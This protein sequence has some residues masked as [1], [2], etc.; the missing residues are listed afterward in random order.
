MILNV[1]IP[2]YLSHFSC[3]FCFKNVTTSVSLEIRLVFTL[4]LVIYINLFCIDSG[5]DKILLQVWNKIGGHQYIVAFGE[6]WILY[7]FNQVS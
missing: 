1:F 6:K 3:A 2:L 4:F 7:N 5:L